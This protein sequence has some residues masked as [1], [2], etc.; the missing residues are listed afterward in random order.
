MKT[1]TLCLLLALAL[2]IDCGEGYWYRRPYFP[3]RRPYTPPK[4]KCHRYA[5]LGYCSAVCGYR[6]CSKHCS[7]YAYCHC[8]GNSAN[9]FQYYASCRC[10]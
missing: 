7:G 2:F 8:I 1:S 5:T 10:C 9:K 4:Y 3:R 6:G